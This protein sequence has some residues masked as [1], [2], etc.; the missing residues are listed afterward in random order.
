VAAGGR[1]EVVDGTYLFAFP[2]PKGAIPYIYLDDFAAYVDWIFQN[3]AEL[4][5]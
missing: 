2:L 5:A 1:S 4:N 3:P